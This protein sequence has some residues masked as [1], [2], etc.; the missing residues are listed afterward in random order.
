MQEY[1]AANSLAALGN[2]T[3]LRLYR[4]LVR[5][6]QKGLNVSALRGLLDVPA[7]TLTHHL[8]SLVRA[9][10]VVQEQRGREILSRVDYA[11]MCGLMDYL[12]SECCTGIEHKE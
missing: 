8:T 6:G 12:T 9:G 2:V 10:L 4:L 5:A 3:R 1:Q 7:S 11:A